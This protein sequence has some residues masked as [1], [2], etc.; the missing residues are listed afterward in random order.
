MSARTAA[1][2]I[3]VACSFF[4]SRVGAQEA[5][6]PAPEDPAEPTQPTQPTQPASESCADLCL[7]MK[8]EGG[9]SYRTFRDI[10]VVSGDFRFALGERGQRIAAYAVAGGTFGET[11]YGL[12]VRSFVGGAAVEGIFERFRVGG[13]LHFPYMTYTRATTGRAE[14]SFGASMRLFVT[15]DITPMDRH[16]IYV[17]ADVAAEYIGGVGMLGSTGLVGIRY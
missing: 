13:A 10:H 9:P 17:G 14:P 2:A 3:A 15:F 16:G 8:L 5:M 7:A 1:A 6:T 12:T 11:G 4:V